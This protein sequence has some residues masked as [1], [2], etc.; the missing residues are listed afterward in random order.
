MKGNL[1]KKSFFFRSQNARKHMAFHIWYV[2]RGISQV[3][4][5]AASEQMTSFTQR[6]FRSLNNRYNRNKYNVIHRN[7]VESK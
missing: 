2:F 3:E 4:N 6:R 7:K 5:M 1:E